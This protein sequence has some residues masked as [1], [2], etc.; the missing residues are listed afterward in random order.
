MKKKHILHLVTKLP[1]KYNSKFIQ[2]SEA[3][4]DSYNH[5]Y[6]SLIASDN[7][8]EAFN[9]ND[10]NVIHLNEFNRLTK[11]TKLIKLFLSPDYDLVVF[12]GLF[13]MGPFLAFLTFLFKFTALGEKSLW[14]TWGGDI[15]YFQNRPKNIVGYLNERLRKSMIKKFFFIS[16][17]IPDELELIKINYQSK[18]VHLNAFYPNPTSYKAEADIALTSQAKNSKKLS[19]LVGNSADPQNNHLEMLAAL[20]HLK[21][22]IKI[23]CILSYAIVDTDYVARVKSLGQEL[24]ADDFIALD[25][26]MKPDEYKAFISDIDFA[27]YYHNRQQAMGNI[28]QF[29]YMGKAVFL[30]QDTLSCLFLQQHE[31][32]VQDT[33]RLA[34]ISVAELVNFKQKSIAD[35]AKSKG[36]IMKHFSEDAAADKW[37]IM[38]KRVFAL[39]KKS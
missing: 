34:A 5:T 33:D 18:A 10:A 20:A 39:L 1:D 21:G 13:Y 22:D 15:Y 27:C 11:M 31:L 32:V 14:M 7:V 9:S 2:F 24:F 4:L 19:F 23:Y 12:H 3:Y 17:L 16:S 8:N 26:F 37:H 35:L 28:F 38:F 30:R 29:L 36:I 25:S 6:V